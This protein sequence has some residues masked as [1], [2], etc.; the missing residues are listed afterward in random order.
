MGRIVTADEGAL[1]RL[2]A[3]VERDGWHDGQWPDLAPLLAAY[4][5]RVIG[6]WVASGEIFVALARRRIRHEPTTLPD[7]YPKGDDAGEIA[8]ETV[9]RGLAKLREVLDEKGWAPDRGARLRTFFITQCLFQF[10]N[11][12]RRWRRENRPIELFWDDDMSNVV[13]RTGEGDPAGTVIARRQAVHLL[14][15]VPTDQLRYAFQMRIEGFS[16]AEIAATLGVL[17]KTLENAIGRY[18]RKLRD[19]EEVP[20]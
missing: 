2:E 13:D 19:R 15:E 1:S 3:V 5:L 7:H 10:P 9:A 17:P 11:V 16:M 12:Y 6:A 4:G 20:S 14:R 8:N 18:R